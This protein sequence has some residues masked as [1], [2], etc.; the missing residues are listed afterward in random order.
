LRKDDVGAESDI[1]SEWTER[2]L[3]QSWG[4]LATILQG[5]ADGITVQDASGS[6][7]FV[8][9]VAARLSG[10]PSAQAMQEAPV[11]EVVQRFELL[12]EAGD[13][14]PPA[15]LPGRRALRGEETG[16]I[17]VRFR[18]RA[19]GEERW[20]TLQA[21]PIR[22]EHGRV[23]FAINIFHDVTEQRRAE[24]AL[25]ERARQ[26]ASVA[27]LG[28][29]ALAGLDLDTLMNE[30]VSLVA[31]TLGV[32]FCKVLELVPEQDELLVRAGVG[33]KPGVVGNTWV[34]ASPASQA[35]YTLRTAVPV[36]V[37]DLQTETRFLGMPI[38]HEHGVV[39]GMTVVIH[40]RDRSFGVLG[41]HTAERRSFSQDDANFLQAVA[42][43]L[44]AA[45]DRKRG[46]DALRESE[47]RFRA[48]AD[49]SNVLAAS[50]DYQTTL[51]NVAR[52]TVPF[53][54][55]WCTVDLLAEDG[56]LDQVAVA[57]TDPAKVE[58]A[59]KLRQ[60]YPTDMQA[61]G[62]VSKVIR[63]GEPE[64]YPSIPDEMLVAG[65]RDEEHLRLSREVG[66][67][68]AMIVPLVARGRTLGA[69]SFVA[70]ESRRHYTPADLPVAEELARRAALAVDNA[71]L[72]HEA[73]EA[74]H[75]RD[76]FLSI[77]AHELKTPV[78]SLLAYSQVLQRRVER[79]RTASERDKRAIKVIGEQASRLSRLIASLLDLSRIETGHFVLERRK[80][81]LVALARRVVEE[82][83]PTVDRHELAFS[84]PDE[85]V[86]IEG[87]DLRL[88]QVIQNLLQNAVKYSPE[89][90]PIEVKVARE[91][92]YA[93]I[94]VTDHGIGIPAA[95]QSQLFQRFFRAGNVDASNISGMG[96][97]LY[98]VKE[99]VSRHGGDVRV[100]S[101][102]HQGTTFR[103]RLPLASGASHEP[104]GESS[105]DEG[106]NAQRPSSTPVTITSVA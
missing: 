45:I 48:M 103:V 6:L 55:D 100:S 77:A 85:P 7:V 70:A 49:A 58:W 96:I 53:L 26:Q 21:T 66:L 38:L 42:N 9:D 33:W 101:V 28:Q 1:I 36:L 8:N 74:V 65:A 57:H 95:S 44:A 25:H 64:I 23:Q 24:Q 43:V 76:E 63:T 11:E 80:V 12:D 86:P 82:A 93:A 13:P 87:D 61:P 52:L 69:L 51:Q 104:L 37:G 67:T 83:Q 47:A 20:S 90:G 89:G 73:Q 91:G 10:Y 32:E 84:A 88:E 19:T 27:T 81:D 31:E 54:A 41:A 78:T 68:S 71:R 35:G 4:Q 22:D 3:R 75:I 106:G 98:V 16:Q 17:V 105:G 56:S 2:E 29:R 97:G 102:E 14:L 72:Y 15:N 99:I 50:L 62:G 59:R 94:A 46:E 34:S 92:E 39:S 18:V 60:M 5:V 40:G 79:E 30:S